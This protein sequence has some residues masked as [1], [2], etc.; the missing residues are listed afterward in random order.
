MRSPARSRAPLAGPGTDVG[1]VAHR[2]PLDRRTASRR[3]GAPPA[4]REAR[5]LLGGGADH[6]SA[7]LMVRRTSMSSAAGSNVEK[8]AKA[9]VW[10]E[11]CL[12]ARSAPWIIA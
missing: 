6:R 8:R 10:L 11:R 12:G 3:P 5:R 1:D 2:R 7:P 4:T 9:L